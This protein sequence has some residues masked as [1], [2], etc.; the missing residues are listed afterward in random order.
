MGLL[1]DTPELTSDM[2]TYLNNL[3]RTNPEAVHVFRERFA[4]NPGMYQ[5]LAPYEHQAFTYSA[6]KENPLAAIPLAVASPLYY[7]AKQPWLIGAAQKLGIVGEGATPPSLDQLKSQ[8]RGI[9][10]GLLS[11]YD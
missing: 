6:T 3:I 4:N 9:K 1:V 5:A 7:A 2:K 11:R 10:Q 8:L